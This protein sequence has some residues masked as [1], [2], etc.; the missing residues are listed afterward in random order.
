M[1]ISKI[2]ISLVFT[3]SAT[4]YAQEPGS[5]NP[6]GPGIISGRIVTRDGEPLPNARVSFFRLNGINSPQNIRVDGGGS[7]RSNPLEPGLY[8]VA[9]NVPGYIQDSPP[10]IT[11]RPFYRPGDNVTLTM[12]KGGV[13]T[14]KVKNSTDEPLIAI[15]VRAIRVRDQEG[16]PLPV[17]TSYRD[18]LTDDRGIYRLYGLPPGTY[19][20]A[21]GGVPRAF[22]SIA[23]TAYETLV[24]T[25]APSST[26]D[27]AVE[28]VV[29]NGE[30]ATADIQFRGETGHAISGAITGAFKS[31]IGS[32]SYGAG[33]FL[34]D[35]RNRT[36]VA[37]ATASSSGNFTFALYGVADGE[38]EL[39]ASLGSANGDTL[40]SPPLKVKV[41]G[42][43]ITGINLA[44]VAAASIDGRV[45]LESD[46]KASCGKRRASAMIETVLWARRYE[47][48]RAAQS[49]EAR[50]VDV[51]FSL[52]NTSRLALL[53]VKGSFNV[54]NIPPG[55]YRIDVREPASGWYVRTIAVERSARPAN[56]PRDGVSLK[57]ADRVSGLLVTM[58][59][60]AAN[61]NGHIPLGE[62]QSLALNTRVYLVPAER[63]AADNILRY[64][65]ARPEANASFLVDNI[66]PGKYWMIARPAE[67]NE[68][69]IKLIRNDATFRANVLRDAEASKKAVE[70]KP[71]EQVTDFE[72]PYNATARP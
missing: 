46:P 67:E 35:V 28:I 5:N 71:C 69:G 36:E 62:G 32:V 7:F 45:V 25:Y 61:L 68:A 34:Y 56:I 14:G 10:T 22:G 9:A 70:F 40:T 66:A 23:P 31:E 60:G 55:K 16:K 65:E 6:A 63:E 18:R 24:P 13:I 43:D 37:S 11:S 41:Q 59:E 29:G 19:V 21:A 33:I 52:R 47:P 49:A 42:A 12:I 27:T 38:Y 64:Y 20:V 17:T 44:V 3:I 15:S 30:E 8:S 4:A 57:G 72:L 1:R 54:K 2:V 26:R 58:T 51:P 53:D 50:P 39:Y 48:D